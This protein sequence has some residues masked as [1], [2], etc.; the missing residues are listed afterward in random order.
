VRLKPVASKPRG[1]EVAKPFTLPAPTKG[2]WVGGNMSQAPAGTAYVLQNAFPRL[3]Y[4]RARYGSFNWATGMPAS[5]VTSLWVWTNGALSKMIAACANNIYDVTADGAV[6]SPLLSGLGAANIEAANFTNFAGNTV[7]SIVDGVDLPMTYD[8]T[9][10]TKTYSTT[11]TLGVFTVTGTPSSGSPTITAIVCSDWT[12]LAANCPISGSGIPIGATILSWDSVGLTI[13]ISLPA[14][15]GSTA[16]TITING[17]RVSAVASFANLAVGQA[18]TTGN[19]TTSGIPDGTFI[20]SLVPGSGYLTLTQPVTATGVGVAITAYSTPPV[21][22]LAGAGMSQVWTFKDRLYF[23][24]AD[25]LNAYYLPVASIGG[26]ATLLPLAGIFHKGG[27]LVAGGAWSVTAVSGPYDACCFVTSEGEVA[28][29]SGLWPGDTAWALQGVF[30]ISKPLGIRCLFKS[31]GDL[32]ILTEDGIVAMSNV[33]QLDQLS[34]QNQ[35]LTASIAPAWHDAVVARGGLSGWAVCIWPRESFAIV[36]LPQATP[37]DRTQ[38]VTNTRSG[39]WASYVGWDSQSYA[40]LENQLYF[41]TSAGVVMA[42]ES[43]GSDNGAAYS[44]VIFPSFSTLGADDAHGK[45]VRM[46]RPNLLANF[47]APLQ[48]NVNVNFD[49]TM[50]LPAGVLGGPLAGATWD[51][52]L[53]DVATWGATLK[54]FSQWSPCYGL[55]FAVAPILSGSINSAVQPDIRLLSTTVLYE[56]GSLMA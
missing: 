42:G 12:Q 51:V 9:Q 28:I 8:G 2:W 31:G 22:G 32:I 43:G 15:G 36:N 5:P 49:I 34:L 26:V 21:W 27:N 45:I 44:V 37:S 7:L 11:G 52:S 55:G 17:F 30:Q 24:Q 41:G 38:F 23:C 56:D 3:D 19:P 10:F 54:T 33:M 14:T 50:P 48:V 29:Y 25:S 4:V 16:E 40:V 47:S 53:W 20:A 46:V 39:A 13:T 1:V 6:G 18:I 35:A